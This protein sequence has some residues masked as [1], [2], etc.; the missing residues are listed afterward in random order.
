M[1][2]VETAVSASN[3]LIL[4]NGAKPLA[5]FHCLY[6]TGHIL[7]LHVTKFNFFQ[8][9]T[10]YH[11]LYITTLRLTDI[12]KRLRRNREETSGSC[13]C[14]VAVTCVVAAADTSGRCSSKPFHLF[15]L[16]LA[17]VGISCIKLFAEIVRNM[18]TFGCL[19]S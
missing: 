8:A 4:A 10:C 3:T 6:W 16:H 19:C 11:L 5:S 14:N 2:F 18:L 7:F 15:L 17:A 9:S 13:S 12:Q 1:R